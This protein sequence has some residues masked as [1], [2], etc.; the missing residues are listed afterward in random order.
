MTVSALGSDCWLA[1]AHKDSDHHDEL[2]K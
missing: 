2:D 1:Y